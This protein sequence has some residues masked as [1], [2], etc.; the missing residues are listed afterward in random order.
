MEFH[1]QRN[2]S[3]IPPCDV[4]G[5]LKSSAAKA[6]HTVS[7][8]TSP[9]SSSLSQLL[10]PKPWLL[11][12]ALPV[13]TPAQSI[14]QP[15]HRASFSSISAPGCHQPGHTIAPFSWAPDSAL[16]ALPTHSALL[17]PFSS[18][19]HHLKVNIRA[20]SCLKPPVAL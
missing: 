14:T 19:S 1:S 5:L 4:P 17:S 13:P 3:K 2:A 12:W 18:Q 6:D 15:W 10:R 8:Q 16:Q 11:D 7:P 9:H 20:S